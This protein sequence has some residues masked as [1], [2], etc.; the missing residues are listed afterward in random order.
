[1]EV[2]FVKHNENFPKR[3][4]Y[5]A[6]CDRC[7][8]RKK[9]CTHLENEALPN[10]AIPN[11]RR[12]APTNQRTA[13]TAT[14]NRPV[15]PAEQSPTGI[16]QTSHVR[17]SV[18]ISASWNDQASERV[19]DGTSP[20]SIRVDKVSTRF[21]GDLNPEAVFLDP[22]SEGSSATRHDIGVWLERGKGNVTSHKE[23]SPTNA[24]GGGHPSDVSAYGSKEPNAIAVSPIDEAA[25]I[26]IYFLRVNTILPILVESEFREEYS[27]SR[28]P[29]PLVHA[30]CLTAAKDIRAKSHLSFLDVSSMMNTRDFSRLLYDSIVKEIQKIPRYEKLSLIRILTLISLHSEGPDGAEHASMHLAQA[31]HHAQTMGLHLA[32]DSASGGNVAQ[33]KLFWCIWSLDKLNAATNGRPVMI[34]DKDLSVPDFI[35]EVGLDL[36]KPFQVWLR[37]AKLLHE[38][39]D[40]YRPTAPAF[41][42]GWEHA[43]PGFQDIVLEFE[44]WSVDTTILLTLHLFY[45]AV[46]MLSSRSKPDYQSSPQTPSSLRQNYAASQVTTLICGTKNPDVLPLPVVPYGIS[47]A[48]SVAYRKVRK[49]C[50]KHLSAQGKLE[51]KT[52]QRTLEDFR[53]TWWSAD[54]MA[55]LSRTVLLSMDPPRPSSSRRPSLLDIHAHSSVDLSDPLENIDHIFGS[56]LDPNFPLNYEDIFKIDNMEQFL[57]DYGPIG[58]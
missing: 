44:A 1:M 13:T 9:R 27:C 25:L 28:L 58:S 32:R 54:L 46:A 30:V 47:L 33:V 31:I 56:Y 37:I 52:C 22:A 39:I 29:Q 15:Q 38:V 48:L 36:D 16:S 34:N 17:G 2:R 20:N 3:K 21:V 51:F 4:R 8:R 18:D 43:F 5:N 7:R 35:S 24:E 26:D 10:E 57:P 50:V 6:A 14:A 49:S 11:I 12:K 55:T 45:L 40:L 41:S 23:T 42:T 19:A 53:E